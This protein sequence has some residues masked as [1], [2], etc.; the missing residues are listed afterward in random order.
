M[1]HHWLLGNTETF[2]G[3]LVKQPSGLRI[4]QLLSMQIESYC[5]MLDGI[6]HGCVTYLCKGQLVC[7]NFNA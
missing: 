7:T 4:I 5:L 1:G 3:M 6:H 2:K